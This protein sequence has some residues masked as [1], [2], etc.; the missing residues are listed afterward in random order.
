M[1][2][3]NDETI[4]FVCSS[5]DERICGDK[6][7]VNDS[8]VDHLTQTLDTKYT[9]LKMEKD[10][11]RMTKER[12]VQQERAEIDPLTKLNTINGI[13]T[14]LVNSVLPAI[15]NN[16]DISVIFADAD[17]FKSINDNISHA[18]GD[19]IL[20]NIADSCRGSS[21]ING[22]PLRQPDNCFRIG[23][24]EIGI[25]V[26]GNEVDAMDVAHRA[27]NNVL[28]SNITYTGDEDI[29][30]C[31]ITLH[32]NDSIRAGD[33][34]VANKR[35]GE[36]DG[37]STF[38]MSIGV[39]SFT[40]EEKAKFLE[41][42]NELEIDENGKYEFNDA[43]NERIENLYKIWNE[44]PRARA[45]KFAK[46]AKDAGKNRIFASQET[47]KQYAEAKE[48][49]GPNNSLVSQTQD[50]MSTPQPE[51]TDEKDRTIAD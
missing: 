51:N 15:K 43:N 5:S 37:T 39:S 24:D 2:K 38:G 41:I 36:I 45:D 44:G 14:H 7:R 50:L 47:M 28:N 22:N 32:K 34:P 19:S 42:G 48:K 21:N 16:K 49:N 31:D 8:T 46:D 30:L 10:L 33:I 40:E 12:D 11:D 13:K 6:R 9:N 29:T 4:G 1:L 3:R 17:G 27:H 35:N 20:K 25:T 26:I 23:G 18:A